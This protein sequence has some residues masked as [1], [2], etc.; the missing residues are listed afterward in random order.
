MK[1]D[2]HLNLTLTPTERYGHCIDLLVSINKARH[3]TVSD[4]LV[5]RADSEQEA[6]IIAQAMVEIKSMKFF[7][8]ATKIVLIDGSTASSG[9]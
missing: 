8:E 5:P 4:I 1:L 3:V 7:R 9:L 6:Q 2:L